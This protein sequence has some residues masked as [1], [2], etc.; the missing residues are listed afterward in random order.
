M[1][2][3]KSAGAVIFRENNI[4]KYLLLKYSGKRGEYWD[5]VKGK[6][7]EDEE[8]KDT[9]KREIEEETGLTAVNFVGGF[10]KKIHFFYKRDKKL[11]SKE[12]IFYLLKTD[13]K[14]VKISHEHLDYTW[15]SYDKALEHATFE[16]AK[17]VLKEAEAFLKRSLSNYR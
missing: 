6:I 11:V 5:F 1:I 16:N 9:V 8:E 2:K 13:E 4:R 10:R 12:V 7:E 3:E 15:V 17:K 14:K